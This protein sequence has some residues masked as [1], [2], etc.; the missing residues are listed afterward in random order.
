MP[1]LMIYFKNTNASLFRGV[2]EK[3]PKACTCINLNSATIIS[4]LTERICHGR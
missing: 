3:I 1:N 2:K 4:I